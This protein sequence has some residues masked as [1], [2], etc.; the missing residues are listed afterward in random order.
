MIAHTSLVVIYILHVS[1]E[2]DREFILDQRAERNAEP[3]KRAARLHGPHAPDV[4]VQ[5]KPPIAV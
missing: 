4:P 5:Q 2:F 1:R 3:S